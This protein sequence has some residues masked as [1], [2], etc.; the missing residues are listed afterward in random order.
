[1]LAEG[2]IKNVSNK[3]ILRDHNAN[4]GEEKLS[5]LSEVYDVYVFYDGIHCFSNLTHLYTF[6]T[7]QVRKNKLLTKITVIAIITV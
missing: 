3:T 2:G 7:D 5:C 1:L 4:K 6:L